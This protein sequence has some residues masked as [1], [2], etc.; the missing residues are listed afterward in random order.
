MAVMAAKTILVLNV[1]VWV[2]WTLPRIRIDQMMNL[3]WKYLVPWAFAAFVFTLLWQIMVARV[4]GLATATGVALTLAFLATLVV[5]ARQVRANLT[6][7]G[8]RVDFTNW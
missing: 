4:P 5:F 6:A 1:I 3:C 7:L 8:D 2:R